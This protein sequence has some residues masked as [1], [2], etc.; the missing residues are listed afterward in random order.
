MQDGNLVRNML[1]GFEDTCLS[2]KWLNRT[3]QDICWYHHL[4]WA[5]ELQRPT[6]RAAQPRLTIQHAA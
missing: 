1:S 5:A 2:L 6:N 3:R 4:Q